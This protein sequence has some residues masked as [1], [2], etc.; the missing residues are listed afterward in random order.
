MLIL[1]LITV[2]T[3]ALINTT[4]KYENLSECVEDIVS[5]MKTLDTLKVGEYTYLI[6]FYLGADMKFLSMCI[7]MEAANSTYACVW[8]KCPFSERHNLKNNWSITDK[9]NGG[10]QSIEEIQKLAKLRKSRK[11]EKHGCINQPLFPCILIKRVIPDILHLF[12]RISDVLTNLLIL[13]LRRMDGLDK[14]KP[15]SLD[16]GN[17]DHLTRYEK[18]LNENCKVSFHFYTDK[19]SKQVKWRDLVGP[20]KMKVFSKLVIPELFPDFS[21]GDKVQKIWQDFMGI[22]NL[23]RSVHTEKEEIKE[24]VKRWLN[25][26]LDVYQTKHVTSYIHELYGSLAPFSQQRLERLNDCIT[27]DYFRST[28]HRGDALK[29]LLLKL[30]R[31]DQL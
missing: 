14:V 1:Q 28:S 8:C 7:G 25:L 22:Y 9:V 26:F 3:V 30:N 20:E 15:K 2:A 21:Q 4:E 17:A 23:L 18:F 10:A 6:H 16:Q 5:E 29:T 31:L 13:E 27:K 19:D 24:S 12:L 11:N